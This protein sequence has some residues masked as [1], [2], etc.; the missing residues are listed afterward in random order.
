MGEKFIKDCK[1]IDK[2][3]GSAGLW[4]VNCLSWKIAREISICLFKKI[5]SPKCVVLAASRQH[6][7]L[8]DL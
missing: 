4:S 8:L 1:Y 2:T 5:L 7:T 3:T 6:I